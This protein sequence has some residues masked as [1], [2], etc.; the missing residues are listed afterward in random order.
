MGKMSLNSFSKWLRLGIL[1]FALSGCAT[2]PAGLD[3]DRKHFYLNANL[4]FAIEHPAAWQKA[5]SSSRK[6][7]TIRWI[8]PAGAGKEPGQA[9]V[10]SLPPTKGID[11][12][13]R[14]EKNFSATHPGLVVTSRQEERLSAAQAFRMT[15]YTPARTFLLY[16]ILTPQRVFTIEFS[17]APE[18]FPLFQPIFEEM[19]ESFRILN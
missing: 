18:D 2:P 5:K 9:A 12:E 13:E 19:A 11:P 10:L 3:T 15:G 8:A 7:S 17:T 16:F 6:D 14:L 4:F 1:F